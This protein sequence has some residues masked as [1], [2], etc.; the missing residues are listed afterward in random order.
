MKRL[1]LLSGIAVLIFTLLSC[2]AAK[3]VPAEKPLAKVDAPREVARIPQEDLRAQWDKILS[4]AK[5]EGIITIGSG[6]PEVMRKAIAEGFKNKY[7]IDVIW[8]VGRGDEQVRK[9]KVERNAGIYSVDVTIEG[10]NTSIAAMK[11]GGLLQSLRAALILSEVKDE[12]A[13]WEGKLPF[14]DKEDQYVFAMTYYP[15]DGIEVNTKLVPNYR[16]EFQ[17]Y[18]DLLK[19]QW[20]GKILAQD[21]V[22]PGG[23]L[24]WF[25]S[26]IEEDFGTI[27]GLDYMR[28]L[29]KQE[30][31]IVTDTRIMAE[32]M[33]RGKY[34]VG[35]ALTIDN[36]LAE[37]Q[38]QGIEVPVAAFTPKE[39]AYVTTGGQNLSFVDRAP[40]P[41]ASRLF[42]NWMLSREG[43]IVLEKASIK[44]STRIDLPDPKQ[45][46]PFIIARDTTLK[47]PK[48]DQEKYLLK[49]EEY[50]RIAKEIFAPLYK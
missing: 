2:T 34:P 3:N 12:K 20:K 47:Y 50:A 33:L 42:I 43:Q 14:L 46:D 8:M 27:L 15:Q 7:G 22:R 6:R 10:G 13:W 23:G 9:I 32:W 30:P 45:V 29:L 1:T 17:S 37:W 48:A 39:G 21:F 35:I 26:M 16:E 25:S 18:W 41:D 38:R 36:Q 19:P 40:H 49:T 28:A 11:A 5:K 44:H 4:S 24:K 31:L